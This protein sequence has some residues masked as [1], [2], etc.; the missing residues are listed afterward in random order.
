MGSEPRRGGIP[1]SAWSS[2]L[3]T[4]SILEGLV[5][6]L[7]EPFPPCSHLYLFRCL[8]SLSLLRFLQPFPMDAASAQ[9]PTSPRK[10]FDVSHTKV[11]LPSQGYLYI[12]QCRKRGRSHPAWS[13]PYPFTPWD[14][15]GPPV[16]APSSVGL[17]PVP[18]VTGCFFY[19]SPGVRPGGVNALGTACAR[20]PCQDL[21]TPPAHRSSLGLRVPLEVRGG[22][23]R[24]C[25]CYCCQGCGRCYERNG[26]TQRMKQRILSA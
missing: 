20:C 6:V 17:C 12:Q 25:C 4:C 19:D 15:W 9:F 8:Q 16:F 14:G 11:S 18:S 5:C 2:S 3:K 10:D 7:G 22:V 13:Q 21:H 1:G 26:A 23:P 24:G